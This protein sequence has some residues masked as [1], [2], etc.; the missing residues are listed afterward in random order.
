V[1]EYFPNNYAWSLA[2]SASIAM[3]AE[4]SELDEALRPL[5]PLAKQGGGEPAEAWYLSWM[6]L[7]QKLRGLAE[8]NEAAGNGFSAGAQYKRA[9]NYF[10]FAERIAAWGDPRRAHAYEEALAAFARGVTLSGDRARRLEVAYEGGTLAGWLRLP[11]GPGPFPAVMF[12]NGFDSIK[13][14]H[15]LMMGEIAARRG[16]AVFYVDQ[17]GTGEAV[18]RQRHAKRP[19]TEISAGKIHDLLAAQPEIDAE[20]IGIVGLSMGG[21]CAPRAAAFEPRLKAVV[22]FGAFYGIDAGWER[23]LRG[24]S[25][26]ESG[27]SDGLPESGLHAMHVT[28]TDTVEAAIGV[29]KARSLE[30]I[31]DRITCPLLVVHG[32]NDRQ[33]ALD[34]ARKTIAGA[35]NSADAELR[36][37]TVSEGGCEHVGVD[38]MSLQAQY[39]FDWLAKHLRGIRA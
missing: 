9:A 5:I 30:G 4:I 34:H 15:Y 37:F 13:E 3:G 22:S 16:V 23:A 38:V 33:V 2:T 29:L 35:V 8:A 19:E 6:K 31:L 32:E 21:Y 11:E 28:C 1:F 14:M 20:R 12:Y 10:L 25:E 36:V 39:V 26:N 7:A 17:E 18:R 27:L 24:G